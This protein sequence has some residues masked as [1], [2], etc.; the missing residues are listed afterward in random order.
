[1][2]GENAE[3]VEAFYELLNTGAVDEAIDSL[4]PGVVGDFSRSINADVRGVYRGRD[5]IR[6]FF[7]RFVEAWEKLEWF[8]DEYI[9][10]G[11]HVVRVGGIRARGRGSGVEVIAKGA[12]AWHFRSGRAVL[13]QQFQSKADALE[14]LRAK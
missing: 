1:M 7:V 4:D 8:V 6:S 9:E 12:Q 3:R 11:E 10:E 2:A 13:V 5:E 14:H